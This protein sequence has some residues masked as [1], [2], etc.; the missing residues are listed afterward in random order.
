[1]NCAEEEIDMN[2]DY[3]FDAA[4]D[5]TWEVEDARYLDQCMPPEHDVGDGEVIT[6]KL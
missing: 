6:I 4:V 1:M 3:N 2:S 5:G